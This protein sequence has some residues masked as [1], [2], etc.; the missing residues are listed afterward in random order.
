MQNMQNPKV[1]GPTMKKTICTRS[2]V[3]LTSRFAKNF[4]DIRERE[5]NNNNKPAVGLE[6]NDINGDGGGD[7]GGVIEQKPLTESEEHGRKL[8]NL[9]NNEAGRRVSC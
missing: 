5:D 1:L 2:H 6:V 9:H 4:I 3:Q 7:G 8:M